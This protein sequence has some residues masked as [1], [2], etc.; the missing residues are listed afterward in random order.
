MFA[1]YYWDDYYPGPYSVRFPAG[2]TTALFSITI[3]NDVYLEL[4]DE[5]FLLAINDLL[6]PK[7][8]TLGNFDTATVTIVSDEST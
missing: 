7:H 2:V 3:R 6:L 8:V 1:G 5:T 4:I